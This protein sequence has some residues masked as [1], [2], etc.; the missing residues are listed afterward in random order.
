MA[1]LTTLVEISFDTGTEYFSFDGVAAPSHF[2]EPY[3]KSIR[4]VDRESPVTG[5]GY[6]ISDVEIEFINW[7]QYFTRKKGTTAPGRYFYNRTIRL[8]YGDVSSGVAAM[9]TLFRGRIQRWH[10]AEDGIFV[11]SARDLTYDRFRVCVHSAGQSL[12]ASTFPDLPVGTEPR[13]VP[14]IYGTCDVDPSVNL[15]TYDLGGPVPCYLIDTDAAGKWRYVVAA[16]VCK[17]VITVFVYGVKTAAGNYTVTT[18]VYNSVTMTVIDFTADPRNS[19]RS[20]ELEV[21]AS[22]SGITNDGLATGTLLTHPCDILEHMLKT[23]VNTTAA[24]IGTTFASMKTLTSTYEC[25]IPIIDKDTTWEI[26]VDRWCASFLGSLYIS[27]ADKFEVYLKTSASPV[28][29][30]TVFTHDLDIVEGSFRI[31]SNEDVLSELHYD[32]LRIWP[33]DFFT[34]RSALVISNQDITLNADIPKHLDFWYVRD[35]TT[36]TA[37]SNAYADLLREEVEYVSFELMPDLADDIDLNDIRNITHWQGT[38]PSGYDSVIVRIYGI[39]LSL[40]PTEKRVEVRALKLFASPN[41][42]MI[43]PVVPGRMIRPLKSQFQ[44]RPRVFTNM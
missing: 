22:V 18:A 3:V 1:V 4:S 12:I 39:T 8:L 44:T 31:N 41:N 25:G 30:S 15:V 24:E 21:T 38:G 43:R 20:S 19:A 2:Y 28:A 29:S 16:H 34:T 13:L 23:Y 6:R 36:A 32:W 5:A 9:T 26:V 27:T 35:S 14:I 42:S 37:V 7:E 10:A 40:T 33:R 17:S 11:I